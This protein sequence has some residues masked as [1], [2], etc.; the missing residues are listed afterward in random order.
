M[1]QSPETIGVSAEPLAQQAALQPALRALPCRQLLQ[2][3]PELVLQ[4]LLHQQQ[5]LHGAWACC[6][7]TM[8]LLLDSTAV[9]HTALV[10]L[11][12]LLYI[13]LHAR[14]PLLQAT[15]REG[16][17]PTPW[18]M[19]LGEEAD[20]GTSPVGSPGVLHNMQLGC[21]NLCILLARGLAVMRRQCLTIS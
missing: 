2:C 6:V 17:I 1:T 8:M 16:R 12:E 13:A 5:R 4:H 10:T 3:A 21:H 20:A 18:R 15:L 7:T 14:T 11:S 19:R 9:G